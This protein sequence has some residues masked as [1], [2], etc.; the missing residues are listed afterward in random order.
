MKLLSANITDFVFNELTFKRNIFSFIKLLIIFS[1]V[2]MSHLMVINSKTY[3]L[4][5]SNT[6]CS[7]KSLL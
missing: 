6:N 7:E 2:F 3:K 1:A 5:F 4:E